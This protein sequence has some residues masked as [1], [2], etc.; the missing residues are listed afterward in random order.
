MMWHSCLQFAPLHPS[1]PAGYLQDWSAMNNINK[2]PLHILSLH[3]QAMVPLASSFISAQAKWSLS[4]R[5]EGKSKAKPGYLIPWHPS[6]QL[7]LQVPLEQH[8]L[9]W[10]LISFEKYFWKIIYID[11]AFCIYLGDLYEGFSTVM[12]SF[13]STTA[14]F[15]LDICIKMQNI[16]LLNCWF[17]L[18]RCK[19]FYGLTS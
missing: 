12:L 16:Y 4:R 5:S 15:I 18:N 2:A 19:M 6:P 17:N 14:I 7:L 8:I 9:F 1:L 11:T 3:P 13:L 10:E